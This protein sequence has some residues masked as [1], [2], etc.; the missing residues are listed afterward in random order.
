MY[1][2]L[3]VRTA[4]GCALFD[5]RREPEVQQRDEMEAPE[6]GVAGCQMNKPADE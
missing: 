1:I 2:N 4:L 3:A 5:P 6:A